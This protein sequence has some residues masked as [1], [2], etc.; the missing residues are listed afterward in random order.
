MSQNTNIIKLGSSSLLEPSKLKWGMPLGRGNYGSVNE[1]SMEIK[2]ALK[3]IKLSDFCETNDEK[4][5]DQALREA[6]NEFKIMNKNL[7][8]VVRSYNYHYDERTKQFSFTMDLMKYEL[9]VLI[10]ENPFSFGD[11]Y[12]IFVDITKGKK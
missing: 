7:S 9:G 6:Y 10:K 1:V 5:L 8:N 3:I 2:M 11:F 4:E 12:K